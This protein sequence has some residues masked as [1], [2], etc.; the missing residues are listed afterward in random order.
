MLVCC[1]DFFFSAKVVLPGTSMSE[2]LV[3]N[4]SVFSVSC[5]S[6][7]ARNEPGV[8]FLK[9]RNVLAG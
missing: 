4:K 5:C 3:Q 9:C 6:P 2:Q 1:F 8:F 7:V